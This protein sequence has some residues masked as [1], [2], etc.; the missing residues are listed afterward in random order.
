MTREEI[1]NT[2]TIENGIIQNP[3]KFEAES[4]YS[5]Y[6]YD[7]MLNGDGELIADEDYYDSV[8]VYF[9]ITSEDKQIF[10]ELNNYDIILLY[11]NNLGFVYCQAYTQQNF[12]N[13]KLV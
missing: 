9:R 5:P 7:L 3:G 2:Y 4:I 10:P 11:E 12:N 1:L 6:Y 13:L 8:N